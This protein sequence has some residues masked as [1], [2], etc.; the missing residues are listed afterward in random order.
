M[1]FGHRRRYFEDNQRRPLPEVVPAAD[2]APA[3]AQ[4]CDDERG[5]LAFPRDRFGA[6]TPPGIRRASFL[7]AWDIVGTSAALPGLAGHR[8]TLRASGIPLLW[9]A[10]ALVLPVCD[11]GLTPAGAAS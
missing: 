1:S 9:A 3:L 5:H 10:S 4:I 6:G 11:S 2:L 8:R 7:A